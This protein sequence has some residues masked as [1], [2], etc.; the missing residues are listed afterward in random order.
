[1][2]AKAHES[3]TTGARSTSGRAPAGVFNGALARPW[4]VKER[5]DAFAK[6]V[7]TGMQP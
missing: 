4:A 3:N 7:S 5:I 2:R 1:M 6:W